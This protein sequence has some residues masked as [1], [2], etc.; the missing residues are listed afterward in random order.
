MNLFLLPSLVLVAAVM[1]TRINLDLGNGVKKAPTPYLGVAGLT[2]FLGFN[3]YTRSIG[4]T[5]NL[6]LGLGV[7]KVPSAYIGA[8]GLLTPFIGLN[9]YLRRSIAGPPEGRF[10][11]EMIPYGPAPATAPGPYGPGP[12]GPAVPPPLGLHQ[13][14]R[15]SPWG[16]GYANDGVYWY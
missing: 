11:P 1:G 15:L 2:P 13:Q 4:P 6:D 9:P 7:K 5:I 10:S 3:P 8:N 16:S 14:Q 12:Y